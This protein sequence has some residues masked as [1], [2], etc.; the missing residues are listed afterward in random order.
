MTARAAFVVLGSLAVAL[1]DGCLLSPRDCIEGIEVGDTVLLRLI[2]PYTPDS[3]FRCN[4]PHA[5]PLPPN[6][7]DLAD[8]APP[9]DVRVTLLRRVRTGTSCNM[10]AA[11]PDEI[12]GVDVVDPGERVDLDEGFGAI[13]TVRSLACSNLWRMSARAHGERADVVGV[14]AI[15]G[16]L[17]PVVVTRIV[18]GSCL[19]DGAPACADFYAA[20]IHRE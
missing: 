9:M 14:P 20:E 19:R 16:E 18:Q 10:F 4:Q 3:R 2:E 12:A 13:G 5:S 7:A 17:P 11:L 15:D 8:L 1:G 6:C